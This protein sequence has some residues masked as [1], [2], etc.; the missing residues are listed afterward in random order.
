MAAEAP[1]LPVL[2]ALDWVEASPVK[3]EKAVGVT[4]RVAAP[5][6]PPL[7]WPVATAEPPGGGGAPARRR[8]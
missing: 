7:A 5:P 4:V 8:R 6:A 2:V 1:V 3:P